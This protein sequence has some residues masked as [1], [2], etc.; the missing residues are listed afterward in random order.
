MY[1][2]L[3]LKLNPYSIRLAIILYSMPEAIDCFFSIPKQLEAQ[4][5]RAKSGKGCYSAL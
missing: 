5:F 2:I 3:Y 1:P 4:Q